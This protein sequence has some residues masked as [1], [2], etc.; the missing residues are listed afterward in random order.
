MK[1]V[2]IAPASFHQRAHRIITAAG[3]MRVGDYLRVKQ[4][5]GGSIYLVKRARKY[6]MLYSYVGKSQSAWRGL[7]PVIV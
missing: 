1:A 2:D 5:I 6:G 4:P 7:R 3:G